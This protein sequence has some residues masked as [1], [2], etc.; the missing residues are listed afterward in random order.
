MNREVGNK[1]WYD[2]GRMGSM[3]SILEDNWIIVIIFYVKKIIL[4]WV[5]N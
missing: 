4:Y 3:K 1:V 5:E 2:L